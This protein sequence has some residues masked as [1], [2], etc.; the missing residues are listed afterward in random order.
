M[1]SRRARTCAALLSLALGLGSL[2]LTACG[3][4]PAQPPE[5]QR[6]PSDDPLPE[7]IAEGAEPSVSPLESALAWGNALEAEPDP[8]RRSAE[9]AQKVGLAAKHLRD[10]H[11]SACG[12]TGAVLLNVTGECGQDTCAGYAYALSANSHVT[13]LPFA[14]HKACAPD[15]SFVVVDV[16]EAPKENADARTESVVLRKYPTNGED[17]PSAFADCMSP[18]LAPDGS[19]F[20]CRNRHGDVLLVGRDGGK[21]HVVAKADVPASK[22]VFDPKADRYPA[23][24]QIVGGILRFTLDLERGMV[25]RELLWPT[26]E[27]AALRHTTSA[28]AAPSPAPGE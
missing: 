14:G 7:I 12:D 25:E 3:R 13:P 18:Q 15:G 11:V 21:A 20:L 16:A 17:P 10:C 8:V 22:L 1:V 26:T 9:C 24:P 4:K 19:A 6:D 28:P 2:A 23:P 27:A 5:P